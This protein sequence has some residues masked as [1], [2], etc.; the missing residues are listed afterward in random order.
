MRNI[1]CAS[2]TSWP[3]GQTPPAGTDILATGFPDMLSA[4]HI[5]FAYDWSVGRLGKDFQCFVPFS[6]ECGTGEVF[7]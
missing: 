4:G 7:G 6:F 5:S 1:R 2:S 3:G